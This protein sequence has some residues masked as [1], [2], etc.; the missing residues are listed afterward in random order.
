MR[1]W[2][3]KLVFCR[4]WSGDW[5][6]GVALKVQ[7]TLNILK[8][9][10]GDSRILS[11][12]ELN[13]NQAPVYC[14]TVKE[15]CLLE[16]VLQATCF[17]L[18]DYLIPFYVSSEI[19]KIPRQFYHVKGETMEGLNWEFAWIRSLLSAQCGSPLWLRSQAGTE[20]ANPTATVKLNRRNTWQIFGISY[21]KREVPLT[22]SN[23]V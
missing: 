1:T 15:N 9:R 6:W 10:G 11:L 14:E 21:K 12:G 8:N 23:K 18:G 3:S 4:V 13:N 22:E 19:G 16:N 2:S 7:H 20:F 17:Y 5:E